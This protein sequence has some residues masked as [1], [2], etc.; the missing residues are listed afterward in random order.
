MLRY[1][2]I[3]YWLKEQYTQNENG[4]PH[5]RPNLCCYYRKLSLLIFFD[6]LQFNNEIIVGELF[7]KVAITEVNCYYIILY[8]IIL[9]DTKITAVKYYILH[10]YYIALFYITLYIKLL[11]FDALYFI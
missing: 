10:L 2:Q 1:K 9:L 5:V 4:Q 6:F 11:L 8:F 7:L 3:V